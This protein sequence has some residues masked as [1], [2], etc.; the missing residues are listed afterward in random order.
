VIQITINAI[1]IR[2]KSLTKSIKK[3]CP[4]PING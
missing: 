2:R 1:T 3:S 4:L